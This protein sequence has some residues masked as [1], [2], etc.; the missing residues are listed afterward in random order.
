MLGETGL[1][2]AAAAWIRFGQ[3]RMPRPAAVIT[4]TTGMWTIAVSTGLLF[5]MTSPVVVLMNAISVAIAFTSSPKNVAVP[6]G[7]VAALLSGGVVALE[8][9]ERPFDVVETPKAIQATVLAV[10]AVVDSGLV[11][12]IFSQFVR[13]LSLAGE[14]RAR[15]EQRFRQFVDHAAD[16]MFLHDLEGRFV[17]VNRAA[18]QSLGYT[19]DELVALRVEDVEIGFSPKPKSTERDDYAAAERAIGAREGDGPGTIWGRGGPVFVFSCR[20]ETL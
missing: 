12:V 18:C 4:I 2:G 6:I 20:G 9:F 17:D 16:D 19:R 7:I 5:P 14:Q 8:F 1:F 10:F 11:F 13:R 15:D 3:T